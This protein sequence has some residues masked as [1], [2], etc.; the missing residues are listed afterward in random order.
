MFLHCFQLSWTGINHYYSNLKTENILL[1]N[2]FFFFC[3][4]N[5]SQEILGHNEDALSETLNHWYIVSAHVIE[6]G[7]REEKFTSLSYAGFL[8]GY[9]MGFNYHGLVF[10]INTL[11]AKTLR[12]GKTRME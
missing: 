7:F 12:S 8:P 5:D 2:F 11:S 1:I 10:S 4:F 3:I 6:P 9:T